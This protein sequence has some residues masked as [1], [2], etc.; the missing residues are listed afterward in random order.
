MH[1]STCGNPHCTIEIEL[2]VLSFAI[3]VSSR[4]RRTN[5]QHQRRGFRYVVPTRRWFVLYGPESVCPPRGRYVVVMWVWAAAVAVM[6]MARYAHEACTNCMLYICVADNL[7][8]GCCGLE[9]A[10]MAA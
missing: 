7:Q 10:G 8:D 2:E 9:Q 5:S 6:L 3:R 4:N 1:D